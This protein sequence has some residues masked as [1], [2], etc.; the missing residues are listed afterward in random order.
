VTQ[1]PERALPGALAEP[2]RRVDARLDQLFGE[3]IER[4]AAVDAELRHPLSVL[5]SAVMSGGKRLRPAFCYWSF[6]GAGGA[7]DDPAVMDA[8]AALEMLHASALVHDDIIDGS[9][10]RHGLDTVHVQ[11]AARHRTAAWRGDSTRFG[12]GVGI[13]LGDVALVYSDHLMAAAPLAARAVFDE[14]RLEVNLGQYLDILGG[15]HGPGGSGGVDGVDGVGGVGGVDGVGASTEAVRRARRICRYKTAKYTVERPLHLGAALANPDHYGEVADRLSA[16]GIPLGEAFQLRDDLLGVFGDPA[17]TGK[18]VGD[19][20]REGKLTLLA[21]LAWARAAQAGGP[22]AR[23]FERRFGA[24]DLTDGEARELRAVMDATGARREVEE[25]IERLARTA[26]QA[27][28]DLPVQPPA[29][30]ALRQLAAFATG[31]DH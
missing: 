2:A 8:G 21:S 1:R 7:P 27:L 5:R 4:W 13:L 17:V 18:P 9:A 12:A 11:Y 26:Q 31:R 22:D 19:D 20:L 29:R 24:P 10:R 3:E 15:A 30:D 16:F 23:F 6:V 25:T 14:A 28:A